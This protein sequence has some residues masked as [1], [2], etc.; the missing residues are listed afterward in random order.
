[1]TLDSPSAVASDVYWALPALVDNPTPQDVR[2]LMIAAIV[3]DRVHRSL[4]DGI[5]ELGAYDYSDRERESDYQDTGYKVVQIDT[6]NPGRIR[7]YV[8]DAVVY[9]G[10]P[11]VS[12]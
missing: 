12:A 9:D 6:D 10:D 3:A 7:V 5:T 2:D 8:N 11:E 4:P 1:M